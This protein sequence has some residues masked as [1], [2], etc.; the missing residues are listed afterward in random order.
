MNRPKKSL[1]ERIADSYGNYTVERGL[2]P[3]EE[4]PIQAYGMLVVLCNGT[5]YLLI[6]L[7]SFILHCV[8]HTV[9]FLLYLIVHCDMVACNDVI[10]C[11]GKWFSYLFV[12]GC[13]CLLWA[14]CDIF[15]SSK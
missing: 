10:G 11:C 8:A 12:V 5:T 14:V 4:G 6:L 15:V 3:K 7:L 2:V 13:L 1:Y 9:L